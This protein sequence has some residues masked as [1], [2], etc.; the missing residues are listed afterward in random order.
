MAGDQETQIGGYR[1][2]TE[3]SSQRCAGNARRR[4]TN[5]RPAASANSR[6]APA[7][8]YLCRP[9]WWTLPLQRKRQEGVR[10]KGK[11]SPM[12]LLAI[13]LMTIVLA[14]PAFTK[15]GSST[16]PAGVRSASPRATRS[17]VARAKSRTTSSRGPIRCS[18][19]QR[20]SHGKIQRSSSARAEFRRQHPCPATGR[21]TGACPGY[22][23][24]HIQP[25]KR[26]GAD[27]PSNMQWQNTTAAKAKDRIE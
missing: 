23:I 17:S 1:D 2:C 8:N 3:P 21:G 22:V 5:A 26:G 9:A 7:E 6:H 13:V 25:L 16:R 11:V 15:A 12:K 19:C 24:D 18:S 10:E 27:S 4:S 14:L 20:D